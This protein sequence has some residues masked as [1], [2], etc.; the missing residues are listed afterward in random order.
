M[1]QRLQRSRRLLLRA[2]TVGSAH[3]RVHLQ[4][5]SVEHLAHSREEERAVSSS[6]REELTIRR[7][8]ETRDAIGVN[9]VPR[10]EVRRIRINE[11]KFYI[12]Y[13]N[14]TKYFIN[15]GI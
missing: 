5:D 8:V 6:C 4:I 13:L 1:R 15:L 7:E 3:G 9:K 11:Q 2:P 10:K 14:C 12:G